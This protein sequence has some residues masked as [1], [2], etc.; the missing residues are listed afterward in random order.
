MVPVA[1][2][3]IDAIPL[4]TNGKTD[5]AVWRPADGNWYILNSGDGTFRAQK[6]GQN[7]DL[8]VSG[9]YDGDGYGDVVIGAPVWD[10]GPGDEGYAFLYRGGP[11]GMVDGTPQSAPAALTASAARA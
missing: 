6:W 3:G 4:T 11:T 5:V 9:D 2:I 10:Q 8:P 7:G 1:V